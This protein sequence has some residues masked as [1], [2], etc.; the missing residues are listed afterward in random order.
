MA[1]MP[2]RPDGSE[3]APRPFRPGRALVIGLVGGIAAGKT[4][5]ARL[6]GDHGVLHI[7]AD[8]LAREVAAEPEVLR[9][10]AAAF[11]ERYVD[12]DRLDRAALAALVFADAAARQRLE[13][14][15]HPRI[16]ARIVVALAA[17]R[18]QG[19]S[20]LVDAPLLFETG[21][22]ALCDTV[23]YVDAPAEVRAR[24]A[25]ERG[26]DADEL[27]R[28]ERS[29]LPLADKRARAG[30]TLDNGGDLAATGR[31]VADLLARWEATAP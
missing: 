4:A 9:A 14:L 18:A 1:A 10:V 24:R 11:G 5:V 2:A 22:D 31:A 6:F 25:A 16:R 21:L 23:V 19:R 28:R 8:R 3:A 12:G 15:L 17:A 27:A 29:Q 26:W 30:H 7:D 13:A 20:A